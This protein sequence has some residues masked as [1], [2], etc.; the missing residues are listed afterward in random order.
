M[1][2]VGLLGLALGHGALLPENN[3]PKRPAPGAGADAAIERGLAALG[4]SI[5]QPSKRDSAPTPALDVE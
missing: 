5:G 2:T 4:R 1:T 3:D